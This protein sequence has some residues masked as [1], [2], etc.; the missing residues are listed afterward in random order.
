LGGKFDLD[1]IKPEEFGLIRLKEG[2]F[3][4]EA[5]IIR[6][7]GMKIYVPMFS[8][9]EQKL[10]NRAIQRILAS[11]KAEEF[12]KELCVLINSHANTLAV[13]LNKNG[14]VVVVR[15][16]A[17]KDV[18]FVTKNGMQCLAHTKGVEFEAK[19]GLW[20]LSDGISWNEDNVP[21]FELEIMVK[22]RWCDVTRAVAMRCCLTDSLSFFLFG[23]AGS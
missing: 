4:C 18:E 23:V 2:D 3:L 11:Q 9:G 15:L 14:R 10:I 12:D 19:N 16:Y 21:A 8:Y 7:S 20:R 6:T 1:A 22:G 13:S 5:H 17:S